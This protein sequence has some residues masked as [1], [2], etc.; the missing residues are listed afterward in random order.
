MYLS[1]SDH[2]SFVK[3]SPKSAENGISET[4]D[5]KIFRR[6]YPVRGYAKPL[7]QSALEVSCFRHSI[8]DN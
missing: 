1:F 4:L 2:H 5:L 7:G 6:A 8:L 3:S